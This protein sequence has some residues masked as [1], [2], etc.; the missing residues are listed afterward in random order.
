MAAK[1]KTKKSEAMAPVKLKE[2]PSFQEVMA[3]IRKN[4]KE[5]KYGRKNQR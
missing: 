5:Q 3:N 2:N 4:R 1:K